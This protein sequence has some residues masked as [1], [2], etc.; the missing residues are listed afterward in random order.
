LEGFFYDGSAEGLAGR[1]AQLA[2]RPDEIL[3]D[4]ERA[5][6]R[7]VAKRYAWKRRAAEMDEA[8]EQLVN[9]S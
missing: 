7:A 8:L 5:Y 6:L 4:R 3:S 9:S 1:L 2:E